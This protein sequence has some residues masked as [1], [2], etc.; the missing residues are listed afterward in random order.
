MEA[1]CEKHWKNNKKITRG[2]IFPQDIVFESTFF[3]GGLSNPNISMALK[4]SF[5]GGF[6]KQSK[7]SRPV[8]SLMVQKLPINW[9]EKHAC[10]VCRTA[11]AQ[12]HRQRGDGK[13]QPGVTD[14]KMGNTDQVPVYV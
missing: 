10:I 9:K 12:M 14:E 5:Y 13:F 1:W 4:N 11:N 8:V 6:K 2:I 7:L 3:Y